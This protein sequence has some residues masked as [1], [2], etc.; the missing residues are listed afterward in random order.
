MILSEWKN[1]P[2]KKVKEATEVQAAK[3]IKVIINQAVAIIRAA[4]IKV[5]A[6]AVVAVGK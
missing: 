1:R 3:N 5:V 6:A 2:R 4:A